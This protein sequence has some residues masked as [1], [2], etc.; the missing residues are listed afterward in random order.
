MSRLLH[1]G[2]RAYAIYRMVRESSVSPGGFD[3]KINGALRS[4]CYGYVC[5]HE[6]TGTP[7]LSAHITSA[8]VVNIKPRHPETSDPCFVRRGWPLSAVV[9]TLFLHC[10]HILHPW[11]G[12]DI[13]CRLYAPYSADTVSSH[14]HEMHTSCILSATIGVGPELVETRPHLRR[15]L[16]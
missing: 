4:L 3:P 8:C 6:S 10:V 11:C 12:V 5:T 16:R 14:G 1:E 15:V 9:Y 7:T 2:V 13:R